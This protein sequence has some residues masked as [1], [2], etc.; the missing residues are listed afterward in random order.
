[1]PTNMTVQKNNLEPTQANEQLHTQMTTIINT[2]HHSANGDNRNIEFKEAVFNHGP[3]SN[4]EIVMSE[5]Y[6]MLQSE[7]DYLASESRKEP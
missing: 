2:T 6:S 7:L 5:R 4:T 3:L 1:M